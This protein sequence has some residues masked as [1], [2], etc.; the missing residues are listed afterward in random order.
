MCVGGRD[1]GGER[2]HA[3]ACEC[4]KFIQASAK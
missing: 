1:G 3:H 4:I 2:T